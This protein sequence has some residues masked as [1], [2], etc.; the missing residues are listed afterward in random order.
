MNNKIEIKKNETKRK[1]NKNTLIE[2]DKL[3]N[4]FSLKKYRKKLKRKEKKKRKNIFIKEIEFN[5]I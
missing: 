4:L 5:T 3:T 1:K 2:K